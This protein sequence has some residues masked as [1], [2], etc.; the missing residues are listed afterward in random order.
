[1]A[2]K[3]L[4][5]DKIQMDHQL[6]HQHNYSGQHEVRQSIWHFGRM[7]LCKGLGIFHS[8]TPNYCH[9]PNLFRIVVDNTV[10]SPD[11]QA[12]MH[13][14]VYHLQTYIWNIYHMDRAHMD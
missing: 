11:N 6:N 9:N 8:C 5:H 3:A 2:D 1:M 13:K 12:N 4:G 7:H 10:G 14:M